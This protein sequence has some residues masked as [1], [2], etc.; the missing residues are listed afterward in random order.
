MEHYKNLSLED[1]VY[2]DDNGVN[3]VEQWKD[4][5]NYEGLYQA[6]DLGR[7]K[8]LSKIRN[9]SS[10]KSVFLKKE[11]I[12]KQS[13]SGKY[14]QVGLYFNLKLKSFPTH[15]LIVFTFL[16]HKSN[17]YKIHID[18]INNI[19]KDNRLV[20]FQL[21]TP[22]ENSTKDSSNKTGFIG[23]TERY[24]KFQA[25]IY[26]NKKILSLGAFD[27]AKLASEKYQEAVNM[28]ESNQSLDSIIKNQSNKNDF[29]G[30]IKSKNSFQARIN[31]KGKFY[32]LGNFKTREEAGK[33]YLEALEL[34]KN[35]MP[36]EHLIK[37]QITKTNEKH[38][39][40]ERNK[41]RVRI[42]YEGKNIALGTFNILEDAKK[43]RDNF[44]LQ[45]SQL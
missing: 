29:K 17:G 11:K 16:N 8:A 13:I 38:I 19:Q 36:F 43:C 12:L 23:V 40:L 1:I 35:N 14:L 15:H 32:S 5:P 37:K 24:G 9:H 44:L 30:V 39:Y 25:S 21:I 7:I 10:N 31:A 28:I 45:K 20:N 6:S 22:R 33:L 27:T 42:Y 4:I 26:F 41:F 18:H 3:C 34:I 2:I